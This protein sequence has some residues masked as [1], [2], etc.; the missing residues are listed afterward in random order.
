MD[1]LI[2]LNELSLLA[3]REG[4]GKSTWAYGLAARVTRGEVPG[5]LKGQPRNVL[6]VATEDDWG[7]VIVP[8][9]LAENADMDRVFNASAVGSGGAVPGRTSILSLPEHQHLLAEAIR[10][11]EVALVILDPLTSRLDKTLDTHKDAEVRQ[12]L[13]PLVEVAH[14]ERVAVLGIIHFNKSASG[15]LVNE[16]M[17][18]RAFTAVAR[19]VLATI[20]DPKNDSH[21]LIGAAKANLSDDSQLARRYMIERVRVG[22]EEDGRP[23]YGTRT[24]DLGTT[25]MTI[26]EAASHA[27]EHRAPGTGTKLEGAEQFLTRMLSTNGGAVEFQAMLEFNAHELQEPYS[28]TTL[29]RAAD[30][31]GVTRDRQGFQGRS[32]WSAPDVW[33]SRVRE[34]VHVPTAAGSSKDL[35][36]RPRVDGAESVGIQAKKTR[37]VRSGERHVAK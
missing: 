3:G 13:D 17:G 8:R 7:T 34:Y 29:K 9:L 5:E 36:N 37:I 31:L 26:R 4:L 15:D 14:T 10:E 6:I 21:R 1:G 27:E 2:P 16:V 24:K 33:P 12:A 20:R 19:S 30:T 18:S 22:Q 23:I 28:E 35:I 11:N 32:V 25:G